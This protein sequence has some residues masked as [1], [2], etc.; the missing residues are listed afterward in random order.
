MVE[1]TAIMIGVFEILLPVI[2]ALGSGV[3]AF[4]ITQ[5]RM[6]VVLAR[7]R[8]ALIETRA[9][10]AQHLKAAE[11]RSKAVEAEARRRAL[12]EFLSDVRVEE[13]HYLRQSTSP[14]RRRK[15]LVIQE[16]IYFRNIPLSSW[17]EHELPFEEGTDIEGLIRSGSV[18]TNPRLSSPN[19][20]PEPRPLLAE[21]RPVGIRPKAR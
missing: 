11:E 5:A 15:C 9:V 4:I 10:L 6:Q 14:D 8:E 20:D 7:E 16:R 13:R 18:F 19:P 17:I 12:D 21:P 2:A 3:I 1:G